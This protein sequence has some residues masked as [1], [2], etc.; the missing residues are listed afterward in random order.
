MSRATLQIAPEKFRARHRIERDGRRGR[1]AE[2]RIQLPGGDELGQHVEAHARVAD[3]LRVAQQPFDELAATFSPRASG[4]TYT[5]FISQVAASISRNAAQPTTRSP[6]H[7]SSSC[8]RGAAYL[9][10]SAAISGS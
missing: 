7:A 9:P 1:E 10:G 4:R 3:R 5:R 2:R 6:R 8:P